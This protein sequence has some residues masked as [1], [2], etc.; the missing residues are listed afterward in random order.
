MKYVIVNSNVDDVQSGRQCTA[1][2]QNG[3]S[4]MSFCLKTYEK[5]ML[6]SVTSGRLLCM[7]KAVNTAIIKYFGTITKF[8]S[9]IY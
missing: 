4:L 1:C 9:T 2:D 6:H 8:I 7:A 3:L 5:L